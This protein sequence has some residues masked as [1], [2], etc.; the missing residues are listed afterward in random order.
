MIVEIEATT[1]GTAR[2]VVVAAEERHMV[3]VEE[4]ETVVEVE[5]EDDKVRF[6]ANGQMLLMN[7]VTN[8]KCTNVQSSEFLWTDR[9]TDNGRTICFFRQEVSDLRRFLSNFRLLTFFYVS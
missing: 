4:I 5:T 3:A 6:R 1:I 7:I 8:R 2:E 9:R